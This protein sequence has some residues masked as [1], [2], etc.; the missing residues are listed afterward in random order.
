M[1][2]FCLLVYSQERELRLTQNKP[3]VHFVERKRYG[4]ESNGRGDRDTGIKTFNE[5]GAEIKRVLDE[6]N[7]D[8]L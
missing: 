6:S 7:M 2:L 4:D 8:V 1:V 5:I 3:S